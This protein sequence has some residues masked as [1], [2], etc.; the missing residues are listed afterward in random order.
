MLILFLVK[1]FFSAIKKYHPIIINMCNYF[2]LP[3]H[4][5]QNWNTHY[6]VLPFKY[7]RLD[8]ILYWLMLV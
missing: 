1:F 5:F 7:W 6:T 8:S 3:N 4:F 2:K